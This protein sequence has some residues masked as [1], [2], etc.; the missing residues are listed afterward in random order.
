MRQSA[1]VSVLA[2]GL[3]LLPAIGGFAAGL[4][5]TPARE[6]KP[7]LDFET[8][9]KVTTDTGDNRTAVNSDSQFVAEGTKSL[10]LDLTDQGDWHDNYFAIDFAQPVDIQ[11][12]Q[13][14]SMDVFI[15][16]TSVDASGYYQFWPRLT[17][18]SPTDANATNLTEYGSRNMKAGWN[19]LIWDLKTGTDTKLTQLRFAGNTDGSKPYTG[20]VYIDNIRLYKGSFAGIKPDEKVIAA[21]D[22]PTDKD[23]F[24]GDDGVKV[25]V[26]TDPKYLHDGTGSLKVNLKD[27][28]GG[29]SSN[30]IHT[31]NLPAPLDVTNATAIHLD[32]YVPEATQPTGDW[33]E[34]GFGVIGEGGNLQA[35]TGGYVTDQWNTREISLTPDQ[36]KMLG[37]VK[38]FFLIRNEDPNTPWNGPLYVDNLRAVVP[39]P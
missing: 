33:K 34:L 39:T 38:G 9:T 15:P 2:A 5:P 36:A 17:T 8:D 7:L 10:K 20:P 16:D 1:L 4:N 11:G 28:T 19:H 29:Y 18:T 37:K 3:A 21:F 14:L 31:E 30:V 13:V 27:Q 22:N 24:T 12:Y 6:S 23:L 26:N 35:D 25:D 32:F